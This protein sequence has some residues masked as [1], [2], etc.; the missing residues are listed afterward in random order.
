MDATRL[1]SHVAKDSGLSDAQVRL[2]VERTDGVPFFLEELTRM[3]MHHAQ[4]GTPELSDSLREML[5]AR[6][7][8]LGAGKQLLQCAAVLG[9]TFHLSTL[10][11][12]Y[13][14]S[15]ER[16]AQLVVELL[17]ENVLVQERTRGSLS[18]RH[19]LLQEAAYASLS[20]KARAELHG[21]AAHVLR[22]PGALGNPTKPEVIA[23][24]LVR[25][26]RA[27]EGLPYLIEAGDQATFAATYHEGEAFY[28]R[29]L[30]LLRGLPRDQATEIKLESGIG[31]I[32]ALARGF[33]DVEVGR[34][35]GRV[36]LLAEQSGNRGAQLAAMNRLVFHHTTIAQ[37]EAALAAATSADEVA[38]ASGDLHSTTQSKVA[39]ILPLWHLGQPVAARQA[40]AE[41][42]ELLKQT[43]DEAL[44]SS[45]QF[46]TTN[47]AS[48]PLWSLG[49]F[50]QVRD[51]L[52]TAE[53]YARRALDPYRLAQSLSYGSTAYIYLGTDVDRFTANLREARKVSIDH[54][55]DVVRIWSELYLGW[56]AHGE[57]NTEEAART[58]RNAIEET[59]SYRSRFAMPFAHTLLARCLIG[60]DQ[61][62]GAAR[63]V[64]D[65]LSYQ[66]AHQELSHHA[67]LLR[68]RA[69]VQ[70]RRGQLDGAR[71][72]LNEGLSVATQQ[73]AKG[74][75][76]RTLTTLGALDVLADDQR[77]RLQA[78][79]ADFASTP[80]LPDVAD[81]RAQFERRA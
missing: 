6:L 5:D 20:A 10:G 68:V 13:P 61:I 18:F 67:E 3:M 63:A 66:A 49:A 1:V 52:D 51:N 31:R 55:F 44:R 41:A 36:A 70:A 62:D 77:P 40:A 78:L 74:W 71:A 43:D 42:M 72:D 11:Q 28:R 81:A 26:D 4:Q 17:N 53:Q 56:M 12:L 14:Q 47:Y 8:Q 32:A 33:G 69:I 9:R 64:E 25:A 73:R 65:G 54:G 7:D 30:Q 75:E 24:H 57:G 45:I 48:Q 27:V 2:L 21:Q 79:L 15:E 35:Y 50:Q 37:H 19:V 16:M 46:W 34:A 39:T 23:D 80:E 29:G 59:L 60:L 58:I 22:Q 38:I 76:L